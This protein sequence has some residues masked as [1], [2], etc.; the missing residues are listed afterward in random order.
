[1][2]ESNGAL[3]PGVP[4]TVE[5]QR[6]YYRNLEAVGLMQITSAAI[7]D[8]LGEAPEELVKRV[9]DLYNFTGGP[10]PGVSLS[11][12]PYDPS[13]NF[14][15][16]YSGYYAWLKTNPR[17][18]SQYSDFNALA[19]R[20]V[21]GVCYPSDEQAGLCIAGTIQPQ[22]GNL[23]IQLAA[24]INAN[25]RDYLTKTIPNWNLI[26]S[27]VQEKIML[28]AY[29][30]GVDGMRIAVINAQNQYGSLT[31]W[32]QIQKILLEGRSTYTPNW[33]QA[34][35]YPDNVYCYAAGGNG[36]IIQLAQTDV[37]DTD[38]DNIKNE[39]VP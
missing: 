28:A 5:G 7:G 13:K 27:D 1:M 15:N 10:N 33:C 31:S 26:P 19:L 4:C 18:S 2:V 21:D 17:Y 39:C 16:S 25:N 20:F 34:V 14:Y 12:P 30:G 36:C 38:G 29:N 35:I 37:N 6:H 32:Q 3:D 11:L 22:E 23:A 9:Y 8:V 24:A